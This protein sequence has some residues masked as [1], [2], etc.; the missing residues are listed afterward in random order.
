MAQFLPHSKVAFAS[1]QEALPSLHKK[2]DSDL[3]TGEMKNEPNTQSVRQP[4]IF[5]ANAECQEILNEL[6]TCIIRQNGVSQAF[7]DQ[8]SRV[9]LP[10]Q[11]EISELMSVDEIIDFAETII[12]TGESSTIPPLKHYGEKLRHHMKVFDIT[13]VKKLLTLFPEMADIMEHPGKTRNSGKE[14]VEG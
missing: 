4:R 1:D 10:K 2:S 5:S 14:R 12:L 7:L 11:R 3:F 13:N 6:R 8:L 9:L